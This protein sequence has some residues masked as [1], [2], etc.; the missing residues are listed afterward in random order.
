[1]EAHDAQKARMT[2]GRDERSHLIEIPTADGGHVAL[3]F[4]EEQISYAELDRRAIVA[5]Q[6]LTAMG[7]KPGRAFAVVGENRPEILIAYYAAAKL[8]A[9]FISI[10]SGLKAEE[11]GYILDHS[12]SE[13]LLHD[14]TT[15]ELVESCV[16]AERRRLLSDLELG[17]AEAPLPATEVR[18]NFMLAYTSGTT[19]VPKAVAFDQETEVA[20]N[21]ALIELWGVT[22]ADRIVVALPLG[23]LYGLSTASAMGLQA[24]AEIILLRRFHPRLVLDALVA[25]R[26]T[27]FHGVPTMFAMML[28][29]CEANDLKVDLS[30][31]RLLV[32]AGAPLASSLKARFAE[33]FGKAIE[34]YYA[35]TE[36]RPVFGRY[37]NDAT[38]IPA[39]AIGKAAPGADIRIVDHNGV[40]VPD[41]VEGEILVKA[42]GT[43]LRYHKN[44][45][46]TE[47]SFRDGLFA[48]GD[49]GFRDAQG[50]YHLT[51]RIKD[52]IIRGGANIAPAEVE[53]VLLRHDAIR[54]AA[55]VGRQDE[56]FGEVPVAFVVRVADSEGTDEAILDHCRR[57]LADFKVPV[58]LIE[59][60]EMPLGATGK[61]DKKKLKERLDQLG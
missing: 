23:F 61:V 10:N 54:A 52:I 8:G 57:H 27:V 16:P 28:D 45:E 20:A 24:G 42:A 49:V 34:D 50:F 18:G 11:I 33:R 7:V 21:R 38:P 44:P 17:D 47:Q 41:G 26:A 48:T 46:L 6:S 9:V 36:I 55:V 12:E 25:N 4:E 19:G 31:M 3:R 1:M 37:A 13:L 60:L 39:G 53:N 56:K 32:C 2:M 59:V 22:P 58:A 14:E 15:A 29:Y 5:A 40:A 30:F 51:G 43:M 35:L